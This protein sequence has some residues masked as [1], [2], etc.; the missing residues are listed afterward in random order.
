[1]ERRGQ[2]R[3]REVRREEKME[4]IRGEQKKL[5]GEKLS[6]EGV[7]RIDRREESHVHL[8]S[9][10]LIPPPSTP[11]FIFRPLLLFFF[12]SPPPHE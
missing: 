1:M 9:S 2:G 10:A 5:G 6:F 4:R 12:L 8:D 11:L 7:E 3:E